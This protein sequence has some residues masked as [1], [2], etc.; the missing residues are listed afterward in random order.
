MQKSPLR[1]SALSVACAIAF[2]TGPACAA[3]PGYTL[4][5]LGVLNAGDAYSYALD[6]NSVGEVVGVSGNQTANGYNSQARGFRWTPQ[7]GLTNLGQFAV[8]ATQPCYTSDTSGN[9]W[10]DS[11]IPTG[12]NDLGVIAGTANGPGGYEHAF[13]ITA[14]SGMTAPLGLSLGR[15]DG[16]TAVNNLGAVVGH[17]M[18]T[19]TGSTW[20]EVG[21]LSTA[22]GA[23]QTLPGVTGSDVMYA[24]KIN[25]SGVIVGGASYQ[26]PPDGINPPG[27]ITYGYRPAIWEPG[28][29]GKYSARILPGFETATNWNFAYGLNA[30]GQVVGYMQLPDNYHAFFYDNGAVTDLGCG[31][32]QGI[33]TAGTVVGGEVSVGGTGFIY[34]QGARY[35]LNTL[36]S[37]LAADDSIGYAQSINDSGIIAGWGTHNGTT[38]AVVLTPTGSPSAAQPAPP[39]GG[40][41]TSTPTPLPP[42]GADLALTVTDAPDPVTVGANLTYTITVVNNGNQTAT[43]ASVSDAL[44]ANLTFASAS[45]SSGSCTGGSNVNCALGDLAP[46][47]SATVSI[48]VKPTAAGA[49]SNSPSAASTANE[50]NPADNS[51]TAVTT[52]NP[53]PVT[54]GGTDLTVTLSDAP[55]PAAVGKPLVYTAKVTNKGTVTASGTVL[56]AQLPVGLPVTLVSGGTCTGTGTLTCN[57]GTIAAGKYKEMKFTVSPTAA[58]TLSGSVQVSSTTPDTNSANNQATATT[59]VR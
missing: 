54:S 52:V 46:G 37:N 5:W 19:W 40:A 28:A 57:L 32:A 12:M 25:D 45:A 47:A 6:V 38:E 42:Q 41:T 30:V 48:V 15:N 3:A 8:C 49:V 44:P 20:T 55:D 53:A 50:L 16:A 35:D 21:F 2:Q 36:V 33:N 17:M 18:G 27:T 56:T 23:P 29:T 24:Y 43:A 9:T 31:M 39:C 7:T 13:T 14:A 51:A 26:M 4:T 11:V 10:N 1:L 22:G 59:K 58:G 34:T